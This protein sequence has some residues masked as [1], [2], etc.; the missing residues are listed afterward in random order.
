ML[1]DKINF[2]RYRTNLSCSTDLEKADP[3][4]KEFM[5]TNKM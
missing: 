2:H 3:I 5:K 1:T 4:V